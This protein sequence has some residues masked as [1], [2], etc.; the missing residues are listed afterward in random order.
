MVVVVVVVVVVVF[1]V[2]VVVVKW[3]AAP[4]RT[5]RHGISLAEMKICYLAT[6]ACYSIYI[7]ISLNKWHLKDNTTL[8]A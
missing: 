8:T 5:R 7:T 1:V 2:V 4:K 3:R 6:N